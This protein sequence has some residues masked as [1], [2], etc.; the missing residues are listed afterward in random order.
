MKRQIVSIILSFLVSVSFFIS[1][2]VGADDV[3]WTGS[4]YW[5]D[6]PNWCLNPN[7][8]Y[9]S[10]TNSWDSSCGTTDPTKGRVPGSNSHPTDHAILWG[11]CWANPYG[12]AP[13]PGITTEYNATSL[14]FEMLNIGSCSTVFPGTLF[15]DDGTLLQTTGNQDFLGTIGVYYLPQSVDGLVAADGK[16]IINQTGGTYQ[17][18]SLLIANDE[19]AIGEYNM[20]NPGS[21]LLVAGT[22]Y[23]GYWGTGNFT[24][25][26]GTHSVGGNLY[27]A[28]Q[29]KDGKPTSS[30]KYI[31]NG[32]SLTVAGWEE[33]GGISTQPGG[34][35]VFAQSGGTHS[36]GQDLTVIGFY[37]IKVFDP[38]HPEYGYLWVI[39]KKTFDTNYSLSGGTLNITTDSN[40]TYKGFTNLGTFLYGG[41]Q[42]NVLNGGK[43]SN[44]KPWNN[45][46]LIGQQAVFEVSGGGTRTI[47][48]DVI[49]Y[50]YF[51]A[52]NTS[53]VFAGTFTNNGSYSSDPSEN[54]FNH[55]TIGP[56]GYLQATGGAGNEFHFAGDF[57]NN[58]QQPEDANGNPLWDTSTADLFFGPGN[59]TFYVGDAGKVF[60]WNSLNLALGAVVNVQGQGTLHV[61]T[62]RLFDPK[63]LT[64]STG[65]ISYNS[66][67]FAK[68]SDIGLAGPDSWAVLGLGGNPLSSFTEIDMNGPAVVTGNVGV[69]KV[70]DIIMTGASV[71]QGSLS[72]NTKGKE[73]VFG[74]S[75]VVGGVNQNPATDALLN[76]AIT[77]AL[78]ASGAAAKMSATIN[79]VKSIHNSMTINGD[80]KLNILKLNDLTLSGN[81]VLTLNAPA[82]GSF[83]INVIGGFTMAGN[84]KIILTGGLKPSDVLFNI[85]GLGWPVSLI[86]KTTVKGIILAP[87]RMINL[88]GNPS[89]FGEL[90]GGGP[91]ITIIGNGKVDNS[92]H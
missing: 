74:N 11:G 65:Q 13:G 86:E 38:G 43:I 48:C 58:S 64:G 19:K 15:I 50:G 51:T 29:A 88:T 84:S 87:K 21:K 1:T 9:N 26:E 22:E 55:L 68:P 70:G 45:D 24:Q 73:L 8:E 14:P 71:I 57:T 76:Q 47:N 54:Y 52:H 49:N 59:H 10:A 92:I 67:T 78:A 4:G 3:F 75:K 17:T 53:V 23:L 20:K 25:E 36:I 56:N 83:I 62:L 27:L 89:V 81:Q 33:L 16:G 6:V 40:A 34:T 41:G 63:Q 82:G 77:D 60:T 39:Y 44:G 91:L 28:R 35:P 32:G 2:S 69:A 12:N 42:L 18:H 37:Q 61:N 30:A 7:L 66:Q 79:S 5:K 46:D 90:I 80:A 72:L 85:T 31:L